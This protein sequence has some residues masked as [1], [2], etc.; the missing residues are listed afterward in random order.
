MNGIIYLITNSVNKKVYVGQ[1]RRSMEGR[2]KQHLN[3]AKKVDNK[4]PLYEAMRKLGI[5]NFTISKIEDCD[6]NKL[7]EREMF[8]IAKHNS[9]KEGYN[10]TLGGQGFRFY[11]WTDSK[12]EEIIGLYK[13]G[14]TSTYIANMFNVSQWTIL[15]ILK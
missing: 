11:I 12:Y 8:W 7:D 10:A 5:E 14:F 3:A 2:W 6:V 15:E 13:S 9:F 4:C 1:T